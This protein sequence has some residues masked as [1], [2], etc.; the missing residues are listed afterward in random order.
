MRRTSR[1]QLAAVLIC[2]AA[3]VAAQMP[4]PPPGPVADVVVNMRG[5]EIADVAE[6]ISR[7]T[8]RTLILDP[9]V[10]GTVN[11]TSAEPLSV[12]GV[13]DLFQSVLRV[14]GFAAVHSGRAWRIL[15][16]ASAVRD[17]GARV[18]SGRTGSQEV[19]TRLI[20]LRNLS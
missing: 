17:G 13:W 20:R 1:C 3:P 11:V 10:K 8:G 15:P 4:P 7:I 18:A 9:S 16:Q 5:V 19:V 12:T 14:H 6:Q 2:I